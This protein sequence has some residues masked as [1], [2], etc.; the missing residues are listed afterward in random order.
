MYDSAPTQIVGIE[1]G[2]SGY[3]PYNTD[4]QRVY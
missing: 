4:T 1:A 3:Y 2:V